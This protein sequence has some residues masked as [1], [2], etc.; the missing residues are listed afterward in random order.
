MLLSLINQLHAVET[1]L[2][3]RLVLLKQFYQKWHHFKLGLDDT[4]QL[5]QLS[6]KTSSS[7]DVDKSTGSNLQELTRLEVCVYMYIRYR[8]DAM[9]HL[10]ANFPQVK[11][12]LDW[13]MSESKQYWQLNPREITSAWYVETVW[14]QQRVMSGKQSTRTRLMVSTDSLLNILGLTSTNDTQY[15]GNCL[16]LLPD[17]ADPIF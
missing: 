12:S 16:Q 13:V 3:T 7:H 17:L 5:L 14:V 15:A 2:Y 6:G 1:Q 4:R 8:S 11:W 10:L 9:S